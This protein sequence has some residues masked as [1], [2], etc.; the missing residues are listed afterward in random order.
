MPLVMSRPPAF[1]CF[2][3]CVSLAGVIVV[4]K[5][6]G[7]TVASAPQ[8]W[9]HALAL[10]SL[11]PCLPVAL[12]SHHF[13]ELELESTLNQLLEASV[14]EFLLCGS[15]FWGG[16]WLLQNLGG[17]ECIQVNCL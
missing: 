15:A 11:C 8:L 9:L 5:E 7:G 6:C 17:N 3:L 1:Q 13:G 14:S 16:G 4:A 12:L 10:L 2:R